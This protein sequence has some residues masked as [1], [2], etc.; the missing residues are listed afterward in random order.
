MPLPLRLSCRL[1]IF[2]L[3]GILIDSRADIT[4]SVNLALVGMNLKPVGQS[5]ITGFVGN[6]VQVLV[7][8]AL[9]ESIGSKP[10]GSLVHE[11]VKKYLEA[12]ESH[13]LDE[14][15]LYAGTKDALES[16]RWASMAVITNKP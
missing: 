13:L 10:E 6:G 14:T 5:R 12:Y 2:A 4:N 15:V 7:E 1:F 8:R 3:D 16:L 9:E 11:T